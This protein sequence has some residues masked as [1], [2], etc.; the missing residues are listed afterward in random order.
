VTAAAHGA[1]R[2]GQLEVRARGRTKSRPTCFG[3]LL[4]EGINVHKYIC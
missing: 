4:Y 2:E 3:I 1:V